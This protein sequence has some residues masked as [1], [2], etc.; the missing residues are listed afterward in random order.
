[1]NSSESIKNIA[2]ALNN[3]QA[4][5]PS[6]EKT[7][8]NPYY[9][10]RYADFGEVVEKSVPVLKENGL[11]ISQFNTSMIHSDNLYIGVRTILLHISGEWIEDTIYLPAVKADSPL[12]SKKHP[13]FPQVSGIIVTYLRRYGWASVLGL[14]TDDDTDGEITD[15]DD[16]V[17]KAFRKMIKE[18]FDANVDLQEESKKALSDIGYTN[19]TKD[20]SLIK[21]ALVSVLKVELKNSLEN[22]EGE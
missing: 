7:T 9:N 17:V 20:V 2:V 22:K 14:Y 12:D 3:A 13:N 11:S 18:T 10:S 21:K 19:K 4:S 8:I 1:M 15:D 6:L 5:L 16:V